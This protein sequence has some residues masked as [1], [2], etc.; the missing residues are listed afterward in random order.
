M[1]FDGA[2]CREGAGVGIWINHPKGDAK[3]CSYKLV[4]ECTNNMVEYE[5]LILGLKVLEE[6]GAK[7]IDVHGDSELIINQIKGIYQEKQPRLRDYR[8][9][10]LE[11]LEKFEECNLSTIPREHNQI[12]EAL[13]TSATIF[14][15]P[16]FPEKRYKVEVKY[17]PAVPDNMKH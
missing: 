6:L 3:L 15:V 17:R 2:A 9:L 10:V 4:F 13:T 8:N 5:A 16:I 12:A 1:N 11:L 7:I 14:E